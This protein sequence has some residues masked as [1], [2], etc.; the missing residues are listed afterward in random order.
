MRECRLTIVCKEC[1]RPTLI[2]ADKRGITGFGFQGPIERLFCTVIKPF[3]GD[4][5]TWPRGADELR[6]SVWSAR[7]LLP[8]SN[9]RPQ[10]KRQ[11]AARSRVI[12]NIQATAHEA[13]KAARPLNRPL[14]GHFR[15]PPLLSQPWDRGTMVV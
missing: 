12:R 2:I 9:A 7:S 10:P 5:C 8:L 13:A 15:L 11:Q 3:W 1:F 4:F 6:A 14:L